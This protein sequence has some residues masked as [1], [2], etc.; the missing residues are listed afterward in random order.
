MMKWLRMQE[1]PCPV[2]D[3]CLW[4][5][6][7]HGNLANV[8]W[9]CQQLPASPRASDCLLP[10]LEGG[11]KSLELVQWLLSP[12]LTNPSWDPLCTPPCAQAGGLRTL[13]WLHSEGY[14]LDAD[15]AYYA[16]YAGHAD[17]LAWLLSLGM[18]GPKPDG[19]RMP[20]PTLMLW[21]DHEDL[22]APKAQQQLCRARATFCTFHGLIRWCRGQL[23]ESS[24]ISQAVLG[25]LPF[26]SQKTAGQQLL[27]NLARLPD[28]LVI[29]IAVAADL[30]YDPAFGPIKSHPS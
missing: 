20:V 30:L 2:D 15:C 16:A 8:Q 11:D 19:S 23:S 9:V 17:V 22:K 5:A 27:A 7:K 24:R 21:G 13:Q 4:R 3:D 6:A 12:A 14:E 28:D 26:S 18:P 10:A 29:K 25:C 1:P